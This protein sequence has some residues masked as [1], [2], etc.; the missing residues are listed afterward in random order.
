MTYLIVGAIFVLIV[1]HAA[2]FSM[3]SMAGGT[4]LDN[5]LNIVAGTGNTHGSKGSFTNGSTTVTSS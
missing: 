3:A 1:T 5:T 2:G 4:V